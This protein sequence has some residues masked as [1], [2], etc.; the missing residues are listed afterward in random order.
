MGPSFCL[1]LQCWKAAF[2]SISSITNVSMAVNMVASYDIA[3]H[4]STIKY[5][6]YY[7]VI[8]MQ[9]TVTTIRLQLLEQHWHGLV[10][11]S[12]K[13]ITW[14]KLAML[15][16]NKTSSFFQNCC[17]STKQYIHGTSNQFPCFLLPMTLQIT[18]WSSMSQ[19]FLNSSLVYMVNCL[20]SFLHPHRFFFFVSFATLVY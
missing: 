20:L 2:T 8:T 11:S 5:R 4:I 18:R 7:L 15:G 10:R 1:N 14:Q 13:I 9:F 6:S 12:V 17:L 16:W 3:Y 19:S